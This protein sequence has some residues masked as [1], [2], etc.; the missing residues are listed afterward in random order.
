M[1]RIN[2]FGPGGPPPREP[3]RGELEDVM[4]RSPRLLAAMEMAKA[5]VVGRADAV[6][7][8]YEKYLGTS[9]GLD[10]DPGLELFVKNVAA[11]YAS[12]GRTR[13]CVREYERLVAYYLFKQPPEL[14]KTSA[15]YRVILKVDPHNRKARDWLRR[16]GTRTSRVGVFAGERSR[17]R[18]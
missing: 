7:K 6:M 5:M 11:Y 1:R 10:A 18:H 14:R 17:Y 2:L 12:Q 9:G 3:S 4:R 16:Y 8:A 13:E 15:I